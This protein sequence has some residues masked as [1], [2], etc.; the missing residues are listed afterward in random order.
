MNFQAIN[1]VVRA[2]ES[3]TVRRAVGVRKFTTGIAPDRDENGG[4]IGF[5]R[6]LVGGMARLVGF[7]WN[8][9]TWLLSKINFT[10][11]WATIQQAVYAIAYFDWNQS[12][13]TIHDQIVSNNNAM[14]QMV[15]RFA[16]S[17]LVR[18]LSIGVAAGAALLYPVVAGRIALDLAADTTGQLRG[19]FVGLLGGVKDLAVENGLLNTVLGFR[20]LRWFGMEPRQTDGPYDSFAERVDKVVQ[21]IPI[22]LLK[23]FVTGLLEGA[24]DAFWDVGYIVA[25]TLD[26]IVA[27]NKHANSGIN[28]PERVIKLVPDTNV[29]EEA[30]VLAGP[31]QIVQS[32]IEQTIANHRLVHNRDIGQ[33]V[34]IPAAHFPRARH[35]S[36]SLVICFKDKEEPPWRVG[37]V[38]SK[39]VQYSI[40]DADRGLTWA[41]IKAAATKFTWGPYR[42]TAVLDNNRQM[43]VYGVSPA[44]A[45]QQLRS[46]LVLST[47][48]LVSLT[49]S[50]EKLRS[51]AHVK[52]AKQMFP[53]YANLVTSPTDVQ[54]R[55]VSG[56]RA[57]RR[58]RRRINL[59]PATEPDDLGPLG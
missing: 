33:I 38:R 18:V 26:D 36:R 5:F 21:T 23:N 51:P 46:L 7:I 3:T 16:G 40:P 24:E 54:G 41:K 47:A 11:L 37:A 25:G 35:M 8:A 39:E 48:S 10:E 45:E 42:A 52:R 20:H 13:K 15:G 28:G 49:V 22:P 2:L 1:I 43:A 59:Y 34:G 6:G 30:I 4:I 29:P 58:E 17:G 27:A 31:Q 50:D 56:D 19:E 14:A 57:Y 44:E 55:P 9:V 12:D 53:A 32:A